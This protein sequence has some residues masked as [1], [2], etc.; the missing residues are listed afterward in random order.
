MKKKKKKKNV[1]VSVKCTSLDWCKLRKEGCN[2]KTALNEGCNFKT[3]LLYNY[4]L[5]VL[6]IIYW[7]SQISYQSSNCSSFS[8]TAF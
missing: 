4:K 8:N 2:F 5:L 3:A 6:S 1:F 7:A